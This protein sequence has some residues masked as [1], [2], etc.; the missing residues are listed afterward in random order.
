MRESFI[1]FLPPLTDFEI[2]PPSPLASS[3]GCNRKRPKE[4]APGWPGPKAVG[5]I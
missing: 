3:D 5:A 1:G 4:S 2:D